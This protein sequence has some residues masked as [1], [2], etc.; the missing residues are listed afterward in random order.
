MSPNTIGALLMMAS[1]AAFTLN[2]TA[3]KATGG[4]V[5]LFQLLTL[6]GAVTTTLLLGLTVALGALRL[7]IPRG[8]WAMILLRMVAEV[9]AA[10]FFLSALLN[11]PIANVTA[12]LQVLP[13]TVTLGGALFFGEQVGWRRWSAIAIGFFGVLLI[14]RPGPE[15]FNTYALYA[16]IAVAFVTVRD[17]STR[18]I[19]GTVPSMMVTFVSALGVTLFFGLGSLGTEWVSV[20]QTN[21]GLIGLASGLILFAY[22]FSVAVMRVGDVSVVAPFRYTGLIW[23]LVLGWLVFGEWPDTLTLIGAAIVVA[24]GVFTLVRERSV[25]QGA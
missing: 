22:L 25:R 15:G 21:A 17:L 11:M 9:G 6:R 7:R 13:L 12:I 3:I 19:S 20:S 24:T 18:R 8:D 1:M 16:L 4:E 14:V 10:Y 5:P 2:D 23:A